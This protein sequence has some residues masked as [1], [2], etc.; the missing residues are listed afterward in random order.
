M[1]NL[2]RSEMKYKKIIEGWIEG[3]RGQGRKRLGMI[4]IVNKVQSYQEMKTE[5][6]DRSARRTWLFETC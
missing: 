4:D 5:D 2:K 3:K 6:Q 1:L